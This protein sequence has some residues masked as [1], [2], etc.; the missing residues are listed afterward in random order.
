MSSKELELVIPGT[1]GQSC[2]DKRY[3][4]SA[5]L[6]LLSVDLERMALGIL[7]Q[8]LAPII[9]NEESYMRCILGL[10]DLDIGWWYFAADSTTFSLMEFH[11]QIVRCKFLEDFKHM[12]DNIP[13]SAALE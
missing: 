7:F 8:S 5:D 9:L 2:S 3:L 10:Q 4:V 13:L 12:Y 1:G 6:K 11:P